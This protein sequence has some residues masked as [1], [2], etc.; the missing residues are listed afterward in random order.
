MIIKDEREQVIDNIRAAILEGDFHRKVEV[1]DP[2]LAA[3]QKEKL[4]SWYLKEKN[5]LH[6]KGKTLAARKAA[7]VATRQINRMTVIRGI[8]HASMIRSGAIVT[9][10]HFNPIDNTIVRYLAWNLGKD[11]LPIV[12]QVTNL[13]MTGLVGFLMKYAD[14]LPISDIPGYITADFEPLLK[15]ELD[16]KNYVLIYPEQEMWF[17]YQKPRPLKRGAYYYAAKFQVPVISCFVEMRAQ[18][19]LQTPMFHEVQYVMH[20][21]PAIYPDS[22][23]TVRENSFAMCAQDYEQKKHAYEEIRREPLNYT[24]QEKD[25]AGWV[26]PPQTDGFSPKQLAGK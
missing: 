3:V 26:Q 23:K 12:S 24:F 6:F 21:L 5:T 8:E 19:Q 2:V 25:I 9:S 17:N 16:E 11:R 1:G 7:N 14:I 18:Q 20:V 10:N 13:A 22:A 15:K 4:L